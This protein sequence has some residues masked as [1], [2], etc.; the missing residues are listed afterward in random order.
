MAD[1]KK[2]A[3][4]ICCISLAAL[5]AGGSVAVDAPRMMGGGITAEAAG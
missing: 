1:F 3:R 4:K 5:L 2:L